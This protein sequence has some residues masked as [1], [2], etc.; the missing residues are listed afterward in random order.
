MSKFLV[1]SIVLFLNILQVN[2]QTNQKPHISFSFDDGNTKDILNYKG[3]ERNDM[4][5]HQL[6][7]HNLQA[8]MFVS[9]KLLD[10]EKGKA[11]LQKWNDAGNL[12]ANHTYNHLDYNDSVMTCD[13]YIKEIE[14]CD[15]L[16]N[17]YSNYRKL[18]RFPFLR[19]GNTVAKRDSMNSYLEEIGYGQGWATSDNSDWYICSRLIKRLKENPQADLKGFRDFYI[20]HIYDRALYYNKLSMEINHRQIH[21]TLLLHINLTSALFL[22]DLIEKFKKEGWII[23]SYTSAIK[24]DIY[25]KIPSAMPSDQSLIWMQAKLTGQFENELRYP[26]E[27]GEYEKDKMDKLGL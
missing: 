22:S 4:I 18:L 9:G 2:S 17:G 20:N 23:E 13:K 16:I 15:S 8:V 21:H 27:T 11:F 3:E 24:D 26:G 14:K 10:N 1:L 7:K 12:I 25:K 6:K 5:I 19:A